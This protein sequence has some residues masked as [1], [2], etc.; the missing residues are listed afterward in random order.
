MEI[1]LLLSVVFLDRPTLLQGDTM[2]LPATTPELAWDDVRR[3][4]TGTDHW[5][6][7]FMTK[8]PP[9]CEDQ[10]W[11][12]SSWNQVPNLPPDRH[13]PG[14][15]IPWHGWAGRWTA[16]TESNYETDDISEWYMEEDLAW[17]FAT[18]EDWPTGEEWYGWK[19]E[20]ETPP[21]HLIR[22][23]LGEN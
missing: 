21:H 11:L 3:A 12:M 22:G 6:E 19:R 18:D 16:E 7:L 10:A 15:M 14:R 17:R 5:S 1:L 20:F 2:I 9:H 23:W 4:R 13:G 8:F